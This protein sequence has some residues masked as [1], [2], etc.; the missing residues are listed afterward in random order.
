MCVSLTSARRDIKV[1]GRAAFGL[2]RWSAHKGA[3][4]AKMACC[5]QKGHGSANARRI[6]ATGAP[7]CV[8]T[9]SK[10]RQ[11]Q[12][13]HTGPRIKC[14]MQEPPACP[15]PKGQATGALPSRAAVHQALL[16]LWKTQT[17][18]SNFG[19]R[20]ATFRH[21]P[22]NASGTFGSRLTARRRSTLTA[23]P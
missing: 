15:H 20:W 13:I 6:C 12:S 14:V 22:T 17:S 11:G 16:R 3:T 19:R 4:S 9:P 21:A 1:R 18:N 7:L 10:N 23:L 8:T 5:K 2:R